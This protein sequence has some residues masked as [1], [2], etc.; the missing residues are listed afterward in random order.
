MKKPWVETVIYFFNAISHVGIL[1]ILLT[2]ATPENSGVQDYLIDFWNDAEGK[3]VILINIF[4]VFVNCI[5][6]FII[7]NFINSS[8]IHSQIL[9]CVA[10]SFVLAIYLYGATGIIFGYVFGAI[11]LTMFSVNKYKNA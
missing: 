6:A 8:L 3:E 4:L 1:W 11:L 9:A 5:F 7:L 2:V 10:W